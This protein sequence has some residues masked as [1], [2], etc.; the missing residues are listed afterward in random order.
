MGENLGY[1][2]IQI[3]HNFGAVAVMGGAVYGRWPA[4]RSPERS[5]R[6]AWLVLA[7]WLVQ[8][9][10]GTAFG[11]ASYS[12]YGQ[13]PDI[14]GIA[15]AA[16]I[17]KIACAIAG[18]A[19]IAACLKRQPQEAALQRKLTWDALVALAATALIAAAFLRWFS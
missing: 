13:L 17:V 3:A 8:L 15:V 7:G 1:A 6:T 9:A 2:L 16:L 19:V 18:V 12:F 10:S 11:V 4:Q 5:R 14:H